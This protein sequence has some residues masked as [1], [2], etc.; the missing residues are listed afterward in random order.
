MTR[1]GGTYRGVTKIEEPSPPFEMGSRE[2]L[3][4]SGFSLTNYDVPDD[5]QARYS[6]DS[7]MGRFLIGPDNRLTAFTTKGLGGIYSGQ[8]IGQLERD[9]AGFL[10]TQPFNQDIPVP[11]QP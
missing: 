11:P 3:L 8:D 9:I 1:Q 6:T 10:K 4:L 5:G 7:R 2:V